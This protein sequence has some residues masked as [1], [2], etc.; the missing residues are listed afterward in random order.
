VLHFVVCDRLHR[1]C[2][3]LAKG[4]EG[5]LQ[6]LV[7]DVGVDL[8]GGLAGMTLRFLRQ[9]Y[10]RRL[11]TKSRRKRMP[12]GIRVDALADSCLGRVALGPLLDV[13]RRDRIAF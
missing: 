4:F 5:V 8:G 3:R 6:L 13:A 11:P 1:Y 12:Q 9:P 10:P 2:R 7:N